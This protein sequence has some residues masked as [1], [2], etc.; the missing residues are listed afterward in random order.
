[1]KRIITSKAPG[2]GSYLRD[3]LRQWRFIFF[4]ARR[5]LKIKYAQSLLGIA[6]SAIQPLAGLLIY[7]FFF[8][9]LIQ[10]D[11]GVDYPLFAFPGIIAW[12]LFSFIVHQSGMSLLQSQDILR[13]I[14]FPRIIVPLSKVAVGVVEFGIAL[15]LLLGYMFITG[16]YPVIRIAL[17]PLVLLFNIAAGLSIAI[18]L[19]ALT[20][21]YRD[22]QHLI[23]Y[24]VNFG[25]WLTPVFYPSTLIPERLSF[26]LHLNPMAAVV[27]A[28]RWCL[29]GAAAP[30]PDYA[31]SL[32]L[33]ALLLAGGVYYFRSIDHRISEWI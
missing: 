7:S 21:R 5:D 25:I 29:Y 14:Y 16:N 13:K 23:P 6:W 12:Y 1:M 15:V 10:L 19:S 4:L 30:A 33:V 8:G 3:V 22:M 26:I 28:Y 24:L 17:L 11:T 18:W 20:V 32:V 9:L 27:E 2:I 31:W